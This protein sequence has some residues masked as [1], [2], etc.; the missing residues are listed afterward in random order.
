[1]DPASIL[2]VD[3]D[4]A[5]RGEL[6]RQLRELGHHV[7]EA[8]T[9]GQAVREVR[10]RLP[11]LLVLESQLPDVHGLEVLQDVRRDERLRPLRVLMTSRA[12]ASR[13]VV[14]AL[15]SGADDFVGKPY[16][17]EELVARINACLRR[18]ASM[19]AS[20]VLSAGEIL[21]DQSSHR[22]T[23]AGRPAAL[24]PREYRL[25]SF[26]VSNPDRVYSRSQLLIYVWD[27]DTR[28]G[29]RTVDVHIR[30]L[31]KILEPHG[32]AHYIQTVRGS[33]YRFSLH[34]A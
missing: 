19:G 26:L 21:V 15:E 25:M 20:D 18:P 5:S 29:P 23:V 8:G 2:L 7:S 12:P 33:G 10:E 3:D 4:P 31:R 6:A 30:R 22:V 13:E 16:V 24:A 9:A 14:L 11:D 1:M 28:V 32:L 27:R 34:D 17:I